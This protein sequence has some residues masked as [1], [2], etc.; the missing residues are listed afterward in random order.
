MKWILAKNKLPK[1]YK[2][3]LVYAPNNYHQSNDPHKD[4][5]IAY[6]RPAQKYGNNEKPFIWE[7]N[8]SPL[9][10]FGQEVIAW[11]SLP[12]NPKYKKG[13]KKNAY[14]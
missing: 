7:V 9:E 3:V 8:C 5:H 13:G 4:Y 1:F 11:S 2:L 10:L 12:N 6:R 14:K